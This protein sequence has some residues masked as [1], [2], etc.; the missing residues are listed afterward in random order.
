MVSRSCLT[1]PI[2]GAILAGV[3]SVPPPLESSPPELG[4]RAY[5][6]P[7]VPQPGTREPARTDRDPRPRVDAQSDPQS[8]GR[9]Y[10]GAI[11]RRRPGGLAAHAAAR[12]PRGPRTPLGRPVRLG[13]H[14]TADPPP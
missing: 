10:R 2:V 13:Y 7:A 8:L 4:D 9:R 5:D 12:P 1:G 3:R 6:P 14:R 11:R